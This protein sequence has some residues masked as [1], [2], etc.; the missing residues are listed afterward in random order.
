MLEEW[1]KTRSTRH[2][3]CRIR[4]AEVGHRIPTLAL[5]QWRELGWIA[6]Y[7]TFSS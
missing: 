6:N 3:Q 5:K 1:K 7:E 2:P 4:I